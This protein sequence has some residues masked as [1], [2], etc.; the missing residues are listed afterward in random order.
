[1]EFNQG[2]FRGTSEPAHA[3]PDA[4]IGPPMSISIGADQIE[5][6]IADRSSILSSSRDS[7]TALRQ[8]GDRKYRKATPAN[9]SGETQDESP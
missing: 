9:G 5:Q 3:W 2:E 1:M 7:M 6:A 4:A 8:W